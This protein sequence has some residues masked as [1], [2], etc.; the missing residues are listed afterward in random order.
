MISFQAS[1]VGHAFMSCFRC[2]R[3]GHYANSCFARSS[4]EGDYLDTESESDDDSS[5]DSYHARKKKKPSISTSS[6]TAYS[7]SAPSLSNAGVYVLQTNTGMYYVGKSNNI[8]ARIQEHRS[9]LGAACINDSNFRIIPNLLTSGSTS[10]LESWER[11]E[12]L[13]RMKVHGIDKVRGWMFTSKTL[14][15]ANRQDA[16]NQIC[17]KFDLC[18]RCGRNTHFADKCF[19]RTRDGWSGG[20]AI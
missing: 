13:Q 19:A 12:T 9:G 2:G 4:I 17:E 6:G 8:S 10:D 16:F 3:K 11:N 7:Y 20:E 18:R 15:D 5:D 1:C 14:T